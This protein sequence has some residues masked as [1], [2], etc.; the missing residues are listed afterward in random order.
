MRN[1]RKGIV[2]LLIIFK[3]FVSEF[4]LWYKFKF[5]ESVFY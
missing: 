4:P 5:I 2:K 1:E 3:A